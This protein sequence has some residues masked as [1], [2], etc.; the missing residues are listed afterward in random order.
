V[1]HYVSGRTAPAGVRN[2]DDPR[3]AGLSPLQRSVFPVDELPV[4]GDPDSGEFIVGTTRQGRENFSREARKLAFKNTKTRGLF[5]RT[6]PPL[7]Y[8]PRDFHLMATSVR[9][10]VLTATTYKRNKD[11]NASDRVEKMICWYRENSY[12]ENCHF[13]RPPCSDW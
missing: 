13:R 7:S 6:F 4:A 5:S 10:S 9:P 1:P 11:A 12:Q 2:A 8:Y 3:H